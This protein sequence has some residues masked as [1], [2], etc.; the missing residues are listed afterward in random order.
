MIDTYGNT[1]PKDNTLTPRHPSGPLSM[2]M[3]PQ[4]LKPSKPGLPSQSPNPI[5]QCNNKVQANNPQ[6]PANC[7]RSNFTT[8][9]EK[10]KSV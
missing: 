5:Q 4:S 9:M 7:R 8:G 10:K 1:G 6:E 3:S 2:Y